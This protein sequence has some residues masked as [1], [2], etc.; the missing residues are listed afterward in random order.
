MLWEL[1]DCN[2]ETLCGVRTLT[3]NEFSAPLLVALGEASEHVR[4]TLLDAGADDCVD[5]DCGSR[6]LRARIAARVRTLEQHD[7]RYLL[8]GRFMLDVREHKLFR[9]DVPSQPCVG[10]IGQEYKLLCLLAA[11]E[12]AILTHEEIDHAIWG[13][14]IK[15]N[16]R[17]RRRLVERV[18]A[19]LDELGAV[20]LVNIHGR[21]YRLEQ[22]IRTQAPPRMISERSR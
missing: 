9:L 6:E 7:R 5:R 1:R 15:G 3:K 8:G 22:S 2:E 19:L 21:G 20:E 18:R 17:S 10:L 11:S 13:H 4:C 16:E 12:G 14:D